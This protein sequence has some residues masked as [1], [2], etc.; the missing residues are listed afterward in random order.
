MNENNSL[1][2]KSLEKAFVL[3]QAFNDNSNGGHMTHKEMQ[4]ASGL[5]SST[6][7]R[8]SYTL[9]QLGYLERGSN[10]TYGIG[11]K[12]LE[13]AF[14]F[15]RNSPVVQRASPVLMQLQAETGER[16]DVSL[17]NDLT[18]IYA[19]RRQTKRQTFYA[20]LIGRQVPTYAS[21]GGRVVMAHLDRE[22]RED[23]LAR[24]NLRKVT[25]KTITDKSEILERVDQAREKGYALCM[26]EMMLGEIVLA[27]P[28]LESDGTPLGAIHISGS[29]ADWNVQ[30]FQDRNAPLAIQA[31]RSIST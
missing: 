12:F 31:A 17:F 10:R 8:L 4:K 11:R 2:M 6:V 15:L 27:S 3:L 26:E 25:P 22:R 19:L 21:T 30:D 24:S 16:V 28:I 13:H 20:T 5:D 9:V 7:Q 14:E 23:I 29:L 1:Y 18:M